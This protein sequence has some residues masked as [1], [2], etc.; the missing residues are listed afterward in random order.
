MYRTLTRRQ[1]SIIGALGRGM[2]PCGG[3]FFELGAASIEERW[4]PRADYYISRMPL[5]TRLGIKLMLHLFSLPF[6]GRRR[7]K[8]RSGMLRNFRCRRILRG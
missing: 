3:D 1:A 7:R 8:K 5:L 6:M 4:L 2:I